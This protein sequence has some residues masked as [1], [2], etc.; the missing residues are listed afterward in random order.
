MQKSAIAAE[1]LKIISV[2]Y[3][4]TYLCY[5]ACTFLAVIFTDVYDKTGS[6]CIC[7]I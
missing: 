1:L 7:C 5:F 4:Y 6:L 2:E 3:R